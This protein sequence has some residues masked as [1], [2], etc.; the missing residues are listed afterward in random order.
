MNF[1]NSGGGRRPKKGEAIFSQKIGGE[2]DPGGPVVSYLKR[3]C[4]LGIFVVLQKTQHKVKRKKLLF[5]LLRKK[6]CCVKKFL[7]LTK[8]KKKH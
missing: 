3:R 8:K 7:Y 2:S 5:S 4:V 6:M 1:F